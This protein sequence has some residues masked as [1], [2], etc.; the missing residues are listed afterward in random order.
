LR[1]FDGVHRAAWLRTLLLRLILDDDFFG[2]ELDRL[3]AVGGTQSLPVSPSA[4]TGNSSSAV[5][6]VPS[7][8]SE[9]S[10]SFGFRGRFRTSVLCGLGLANRESSHAGSSVLPSHVDRVDARNWRADPQPTDEHL[11][12]LAGSLKPDFHPA[13]PQIASRGRSTSR[14]ASRGRRLAIPTPPAP[15]A[16]EA[17]A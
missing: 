9:G 4:L 12:A 5:G 17:V 14:L 3:L 8:R 6:S 11:D 15:V 13:V 2:L 7:S 1:C 16:H 10:R